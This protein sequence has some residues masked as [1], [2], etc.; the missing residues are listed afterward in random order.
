MILVPQM[1]RPSNRRPP[2][3]LILE[4][5]KKESKL[6]EM[7]ELSIEQSLSDLKSAWEIQTNKKI[8]LN[9]V[10]REVGNHLKTY[11]CSVEERRER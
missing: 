6:R 5:R 7:E 11:E 2:E 4:N 9:R 3:Y 10:R 1:A 8:M